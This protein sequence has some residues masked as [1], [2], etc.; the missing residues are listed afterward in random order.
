M[1]AR[2]LR[3]LRQPG[4]Q[5]LRLGQPLG[6]SM[7]RASEWTPGVLMQFR[8]LSKQADTAIEEEW[9]EVVDPAGSGKTYW[10]NKRTN[11]TTTLGASRPGSFMAKAR[12][13]KDDVARD[14]NR[15][16]GASS[17]SATEEAT[18]AEAAAAPMVVAEAPADEGGLPLLT[19]EQDAQ[20]EMMQCLFLPALLAA[21]PAMRS[22]DPLAVTGRHSTSTCHRAPAA[23]LYSAQ[24]NTVDGRNPAP[25]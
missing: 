16:Q 6:S 10:W 1:A 25:L 22:G 11:E 9:T 18:M 5:V 24:P 3:I 20:A 12:S 4:S 19:A 17:S 23:G 15:R 2:A 14:I 21:S 13:F 7:S 8:P